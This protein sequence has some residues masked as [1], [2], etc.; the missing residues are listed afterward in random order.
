M[1]HAPR[2]IRGTLLL[3]LGLLACSA[4]KDREEQCKEVIDHLR[5][6]SAMPMREG[7]RM[8]LEGAC[9]SW[10]E[11]T[12]DCVLEAKNDTEVDAC[13]AK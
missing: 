10:N 11:M 1:C 12:I 2:M 4:K 7:D 8:M 6:V 9:K 13:K 3:G 5:D